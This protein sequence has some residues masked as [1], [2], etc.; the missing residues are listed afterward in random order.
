MAAVAVPNDNFAD[1]TVLSGA[2]LSVT[3]SNAGATKEVGEPDIAGFAGGKSVWYSWT[4]PS[5]GA[6]TLTTTGS[7]FDTLLGVYTGSAVSALTLIAANDD[8]NTG[9]ITTSALSFGAIAGTTYHFA[10]DGW[11]CGSRATSSSI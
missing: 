9:T 3:G 11:E 1:A 8:Y 6:V 7:N 4:A 2:T 10:V 5:T